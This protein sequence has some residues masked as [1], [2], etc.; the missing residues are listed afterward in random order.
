MAGLVNFF[1]SKIV[2]RHQ[3]RCVI[4]GLDAAGKTTFLYKCVLPGETITTIPTIGFNVETVK[5]NDSDITLWDIGGC[6]K[7][8]PLIR[9]YFS[10]GMALLFILDIH[11]GR[12]DEAMEE[13][14]YQVS[15]ATTNFDAGFV[16][17]MFNKQDLPGS[18]PELRAKCR[19]VV[20][21]N[22]NG[23]RIKW[24]IFDSDALSSK[25]GDGVDGVL[26]GVYEGLR[27]WVPDPHADPIDKTRIV[28]PD[29]VPTRGELLKRIKSL[30]ESKSNVYRYS[31]V[32]LNKMRTGKLETW[33]HS[34]HLYVANIL[35]R[36]VLEDPSQTTTPQQPVFAAVDMF[37]D[38]LV[39][40]LQEAPGRF[41]NTAHQTLTTFWVHQVYLAMHRFKDPVS[42]SNQAA[43][44]SDRFFALLE[45]NP[46]L[47]NGRLWEEYYSKNHLFSPK[48]KENL[49]TPD[50]QQLPSVDTSEKGAR[51]TAYNSQR[52]GEDQNSRRLKRWAY[53]TLQTVKAT[54][55]RRGLIVKKALSE[56]QRDTI[57]KR[58][59]EQTVEPYSETQ[60]YFW[61]QI[62]HAGM[63]G[64]LKKSPTFDFAR[65]SYDSI[66]ILYPDVF[67][68]DDLWKEYYLESDWKGLTARVNFIPPKKGKVIPNFTPTFALEQDWKLA[69]SEVQI[70]T[71]EELMQRADYISNYE[72]VAKSAT[73]ES[74][75]S[76][77]K[78]MDVRTGQLHD[79]DDDDDWVEVRE[80]TAKVV[81]VKISEPEKLSVEVSSP[82]TWEDQA[83]LIHQI[84]NKLPKLES[85]IN[86]SFISKIAYDEVNKSWSQN[87]QSEQTHKLHSQLTK[88]TFWVRM[89]VEA[90]IDTYG[91][92]LEREKAILEGREDST[93]N[94]RGF[95][96]KNL[97]L[98]WEDL[99]MVYYNELTWKSVTATEM[100]LGCDRKQLRSVR[101]WKERSL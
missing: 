37:L 50:I 40:M 42:H 60:A 43:S 77:P 53:A 89:I 57:R 6:D 41:R 10:S 31:D 20:E 66:E 73:T 35:L 95:L 76:G 97:E 70:P 94:L 15:E 67:G 79:E 93:I 7:I 62:V 72:V 21:D 64:I 96:S 25:T 45:Q 28:Q 22:M 69:V 86:H 59:K 48:A 34:D 91:P 5:I 11:D 61:I 51:E 39:S 12:L 23:F 47:M 84:F 81:E 2:G 18:T 26:Q 36:K 13:L 80:V 56:L 83:E 71:M 101:G 58:A 85:Q 38:N 27:G 52:L 1:K 100:I 4:L 63:E 78:P 90:Y 24:R 98:C 8:R 16:G 75:L 32:Y 44:W 33:D 14:R 74:K 68:S 17:I 87:P 88:M 30:K 55:A 82:Q 9:H 19:R 3:D 49:V 65:V 46:E 54:N 29:T 92:S 99:W